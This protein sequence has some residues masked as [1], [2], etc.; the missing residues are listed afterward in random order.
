MG[1]VTVEDGVFPLRDLA[2]DRCGKRFVSSW[3]EQMPPMTQRSVRYFMSERGMESSRFYKE[4]L[5]RVLN[6]E[7]TWRINKRNNTVVCNSC[8]MI[9]S[10]VRKA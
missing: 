1:V 2:C 9:I 6:G 7:T 5:K 8:P 3:F 4:V 10:K